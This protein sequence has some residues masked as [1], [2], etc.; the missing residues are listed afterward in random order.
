MRPRLADEKGFGLIELL[1]AL[2][3]LNVGIFALLGTFQAGAAA[4]T[5]SAVTSNGTAVADKVLEVYRGLQ[6]KAIYLNAPASGGS[7][8][9]GYPNGIPNST[10]TWYARY[11]GDTAAYPGTAYYSY[12][13]PA[14]TP[15][16]VTQ[17]TTASSSTTPIPTTDTTVVPTGLA[18]TPT[19]AVQGV[20]GPDGQTYP[21]CTYIVMLQLSVSNSSGTVTTGGWVKQ[22]TVVVRDP[23]NTSR[24]IARESALFDP[25]VAP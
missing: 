12:A 11:Q 20:A 16:W 3:M 25:T 8:V 6:N 15:N 7:D 9:S 17:S 14:S 2:V 23:L 24:V 19:A 10:S 1:F 5:R 21:V 4:I 18:I 22:V 13:S